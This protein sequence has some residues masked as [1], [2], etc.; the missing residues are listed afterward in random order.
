MEITIAVTTTPSNGEHWQVSEHLDLCAFTFHCRKISLDQTSVVIGTARKY[1][2][3]IRPL[4]THCRQAIVVVTPNYT[5]VVEWINR[6]F[7]LSICA[8]S[9]PVRSTKFVMNG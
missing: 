3:G 5:P 8:G 4:Q 7:L 9:N 2:F 1:E 6:R